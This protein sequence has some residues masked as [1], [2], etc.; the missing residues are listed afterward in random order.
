MAAWWLTRLGDAAQRPAVDDQGHVDDV[1]VLDR[2]VALDGELRLGVGTVVEQPFEA[3]ELA[4]RIRSV[5]LGDVEVLAL[6]DDPHRS[7]S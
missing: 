5:G 1:A 2:L 6:D 4:L 3:A 7:A